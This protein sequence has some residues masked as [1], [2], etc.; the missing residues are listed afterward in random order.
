MQS[1]SE[2]QTYSNIQ[3]AGLSSCE[4]LIR[5]SC[6]NHTKVHND[7]EHFWAMAHFGTAMHTK[8]LTC[9]NTTNTT[10]STS[11]DLQLL[12]YQPILPVHQCL[13]GVIYSSGAPPGPGDIGLSR[14]TSWC[15]LPDDLLRFQCVSY[16]WTLD[17]TGK[18]LTLLCQRWN[19]WLAHLALSSP[20]SS[21]TIALRVLIKLF[22]SFNAKP[23]GSVG[24]GSCLS[25]V[26]S[27][28][29]ALGF[30]ALAIKA[31]HLL[32]FST[33][34]SLI[35]LQR[36]V[37]RHGPLF[38]NQMCFNQLANRPCLLQVYEYGRFFNG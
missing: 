26:G 38:P 25:S 34:K 37:Q 13:Q 21:Q 14:A 31:Y 19:W 17:D 23:V 20:A 24:I 28:F 32:N 15:V 10:I 35:L 27:L 11:L 2:V 1:L 12:Q 36:F 22:D 30:V 5:P 7:F 29:Q 6:W 33:V 16:L 4:C 3:T 9:T 8:R 18:C